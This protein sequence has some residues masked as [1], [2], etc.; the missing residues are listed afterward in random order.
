MPE[1]SFT[2]FEHLE[3]LNQS[4]GMTVTDIMFNLI[5]LLFNEIN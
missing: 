3:D 2:Y 4:K 5:A 1:V